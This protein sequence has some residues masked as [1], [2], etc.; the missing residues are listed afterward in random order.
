MERKFRFD[1]V[2]KTIVGSK[3]SIEKA[4]KGLDPEFGELSK[5]LEAQPTFKVV[6]KQINAKE[7]KDTHKG[8]TYKR[9][10]SFI[11]LLDNKE[12]LMSEFRAVKKY[13]DTCGSAYPSTK[14][15]FLDTFPQFRTAKTDEEQKDFDART[16]AIVNEIARREKV[17]TIEDEAKVA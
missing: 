8:L 5:M 2:E 11:N 3:R 7:G 16:A 15:W 4:N 6:V 13:G 9:M 12:E 1:F 14:K 10:E 17:R